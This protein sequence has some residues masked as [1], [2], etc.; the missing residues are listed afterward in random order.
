MDESFQTNP[1][2]VSTCPHL[3]FE[4]DPGTAMAIPAPENFCHRLSPPRCP[5]AQHQRMY[6]LSSNHITCPVF[7]QEPGSK[8]VPKNIFHTRK[9]TSPHIQARHIL[10][11]LLLAG[12]GVLV[13]LLYTGLIK[14]PSFSSRNP[15]ATAVAYT[16]VLEVLLP[17]LTPTPVFTITVTRTPLPPTPT[18]TPVQ[19][20]LLE[21]PVSPL[22]RE[23]IV[24]RALPGE[25]VIMLAEM[26]FTSPDAIRAVNYQM[27]VSLWEDMLVVV[28]YMHKNVSNI[29]PM[30]VYQVT[31]EN[32]TMETLARQLYK[33]VN[34]LLETNQ[35]P[36]G[37]TLQL[38]EYVLIPFPQALT[39]TQLPW[40]STSTP[41]P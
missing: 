38:G 34:L 8:A 32:L 33:D 25:S 21:T 14:L 31:E 6:C 35:R 9:R 28:P 2:N 13:A 18:I 16:P 17:T 19:P 1:D 26:Y 22:G 36:A 10:L 4:V 15:V 7:N 29:A 23:F 24:H 11:A 3:G 39:P 5:I 40:E 20:L 12:A 37:Y 30:T 27:A 41:L